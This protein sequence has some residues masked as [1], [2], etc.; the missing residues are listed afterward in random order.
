MK[1]TTTG[2]MGVLRSVDLEMRLTHRQI[3]VET[4]SI[5]LITSQG[6]RS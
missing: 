5:S 3:A 6:E 4:R 2:P 1:Y